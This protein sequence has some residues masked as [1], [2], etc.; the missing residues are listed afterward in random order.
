MFE[1]RSAING[2]LLWFLLSKDD[3]SILVFC[4]IFCYTIESKGSYLLEANQRNI[5]TTT[6]LSLVQ[7]FIID[8]ASAENKSLKDSR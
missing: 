1:I 6:L 5:L 4:S 7:Q 2:Y 8:L 3:L